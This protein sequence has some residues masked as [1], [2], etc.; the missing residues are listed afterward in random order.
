MDTHYYVNKKEVTFEE[1][2]K[3]LEE[4]VVS[5]GYYTYKDFRRVA[6]MTGEVTVKDTLFE[7]KLF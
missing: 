4:K 7:T 3:T 6:L 2:N 1:F 5:D